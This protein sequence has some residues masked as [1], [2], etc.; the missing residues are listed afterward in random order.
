[1]ILRVN[2]ELPQVRQR[3]RRRVS[4]LPFAARPLPPRV[5]P[6]PGVLTPVVHQL[7]HLGIVRQVHGGAQSRAID[8]VP[9]VRRRNVRRGESTWSLAPS[10][11]AGGLEAH[12]ALGFTP[13]VGRPPA[14]DDHGLPS[15]PPPWF[16]RGED[17]G[18]RDGGAVDAPHPR[19]DLDGAS[20]VERSLHQHP[21]VLVGFGPGVHHG[22]DVAEGE[23]RGDE[24]R[25]S[26]VQLAPLP[27]VPIELPFAQERAHRAGADEERV[28]EQGAR[29]GARGGSRGARVGGGCGEPG[30][31]GGHP[32]AEGARRVLRWLGAQPRPGLL[33]LGRVVSVG[34]Y[35]S[36]RSSSPG[37]EAQQQRGPG[38]LRHRR[39]FV[40]TRVT[41]WSRFGAVKKQSC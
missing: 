20:D 19:A 29:A 7:D 35:P 16:A 10:N 34:E 12:A 22:R 2:L 41:L 36:A 9:R 38:R 27:L 11:D 37:R 6:V 28:P 8:P 31:G 39:A 25:L 13:V 15:L 33:A 17:D 24:R 30:R 32:L 3:H 40:S 5:E 26:R 14:V 1:M 18:A 21:G 4:A 23:V